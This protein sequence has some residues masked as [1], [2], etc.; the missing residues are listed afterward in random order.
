MDSSR[1]I[2]AFVLSAVLLASALLGYPLAFCRLT[3]ELL[4]LYGIVRFITFPVLTLIS[5]A[6]LLVFPSRCRE[7]LCYRRNR[8]L[9]LTAGIFLLVNLAHTLLAGLPWN[10]FLSAAFFV[11]CP[12]AAAV[13][14]PEL[15]KIFPAF[16]TAAGILWV[17]SGLFSLNFTGLS[18]NWNWTQGIIAA[19]LPGIFV[20]INVRYRQWLVLETLILFCLLILVLF[21]DEFSRSALTAICVTAVIFC[22]RQKVHG[23]VFNRQL[24]MA[25]FLL[26]AVF[27]F[28]VMKLNLP[29]TRFQIWKG[30]VNLISD[31][32]F[33]GVGWGQFADNIRQ[34]YTEEFFFSPFPALQTDHAH[35][36]FL[37]MLAGCG[38]AGA[39][40]YVTA[41]CRIFC[42]RMFYSVG[43]F[44]YWAAGVLL[45]CGCF[46]QH[47]V[48]IAGGVL[49]AI[50]A[51]CVLAPWRY[52]SDAVPSHYPAALTVGRVCAVLL[53]FAAI[54]IALTDFRATTL[55]RQGDLFRNRGDYFTARKKYL[56][57]MNTALTP[58]A[59]YN[60]AELH[61]L[62]KNP[63]KTLEYT[64]KLESEFSLINY[65]HTQRLKGIAAL[66][67]GDMN[68]ALTAFEK[69]NINAPFSVINARYMRM[70]MRHIHASDEAVAEADQHFL[71]LCSMRGISPD[72]ADS[73]RLE[74]D[75]GAFPPEVQQKRYAGK[76]FL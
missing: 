49:L 70:I 13:L 38:I 35:N 8:F 25:I 57:S 11:F 2:P 67:T 14:A 16:A 62:M 3:G 36:D 63:A 5:V 64:G 1:N 75:D 33:A 46:D 7:L 15:R 34:Y 68:A 31:R 44:F 50:S 43:Q 66:Q 52:R 76:I 27:F 40:F 12:S 28:L 6:I 74:L 41:L 37:N 10:S 55:L 39:L 48:S 47:N 9:L 59:L 56:E 32:W 24:L 19:L 69:E 45:I 60:S 53:I 65:C 20:I 30:A 17:Y 72:E 61:L 21:P 71:S 22:W 73:I 29:D 18:G 4:P 42:H 54:N 58:E 26:T 51:G 23:K